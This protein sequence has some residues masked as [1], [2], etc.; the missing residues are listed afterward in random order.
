MTNKI[1]HP[2]MVT[3][4]MKDPA[5]ILSEMSVE[6]IHLVHAAS[7]ITGEAGEISDIIKKFAFNNI[8][9]DNVKLLKELGD[10]EFYLEALRQQLGVTRDQ[11][12]AINIAKL[13]DRYE[14][15]VYSD[16]AALERK[17]QRKFLGQGENN[18]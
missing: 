18:G 8:P 17:D 9:L 16:K 15:F 12:I 11:V 10:L 7:G 3:A 13:A 2:E 6:K 4:L 14:G 5:V 1:S